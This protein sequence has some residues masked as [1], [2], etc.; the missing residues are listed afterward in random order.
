ME[1]K[2]TLKQ[3]FKQISESNLFKD[4]IKENPKAELC[5]GFFVIDLFGNDNKKSLD[6]RVGEKI[7]SFSINEL[8]KIK[9]NEDKLVTDESRS[10]PKLEVIEPFVNSDLD[11]VESA[12]K[13]RALDEGISAKFSKIIAVL[14]KYEHEK[15]NKQIWNLTCMLEGLIILHI[16]VDSQ[17]GEIIKFE[18]KSMMDMIRKK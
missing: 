6:Y 16:L 1:E 12:A 11:E 9:M 14:Q 15:K 18:R 13:I 7:F 10:F 3:T 8:G 2:T 17:T 5:A 4:F